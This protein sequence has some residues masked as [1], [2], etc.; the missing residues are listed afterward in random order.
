[1]LRK[2]HEYTRFHEFP[3]QFEERSETIGVEI[4]PQEKDLWQIT[5][6]VDNMDTVVSYSAHITMLIYVYVIIT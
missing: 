6:F 3:V 4:T 1:M 2:Y 5:S